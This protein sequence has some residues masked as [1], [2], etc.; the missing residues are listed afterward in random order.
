MLPKC[1]GLGGSAG[2]EIEY[3]EGKYDVLLTSELG[4]TYG[5]IIG[6]E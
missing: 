6:C 1:S 3:M 2:G 4:E 5:L